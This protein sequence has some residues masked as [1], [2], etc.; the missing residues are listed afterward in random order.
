[1]F[2]V[3]VCV[4]APVCAGMPGGEFVFPGSVGSTRLPYDHVSARSGAGEE[5]CESDLALV[6]ERVNEE[7][8]EWQ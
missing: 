8:Q 5:G 4:C 3:Y 2:C 7:G 6:G 1:M